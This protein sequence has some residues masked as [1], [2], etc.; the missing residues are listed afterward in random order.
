[1]KLLKKLYDKSSL[2]FTLMWIVIYII[3]FSLGDFVSSIIKINKL[4]TFIIGI[5]ISLILLLFLKKYNLLSTY[6]LKKSDIHPKYMLFYI[7]CFIMLILN[8]YL[9]VTLNFSPLETI[10][11]IL[12]MFLVGL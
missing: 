4:F 2:F 5:I 11:Y 7:P 8:L 3:G 1:M 9:G 10:F 6:G 12:S